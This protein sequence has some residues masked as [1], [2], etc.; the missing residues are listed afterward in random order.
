MIS[1]ETLE[2]SNNRL[3]DLEEVEKLASLPSMV[4]LRMVNN[5]LTK[6]HLY[7]QH[8]L[9][10]LNS[11]K[12][13]DGKDVY[14]DEKERIE[15]LFAAAAAS[16]TASERGME[17]RPVYPTQLVL[18]PSSIP[19]KGSSSVGIP[20]PIEVLTGSHL[21]KTNSPLFSHGQMPVSAPTFPLPE[22]E[23]DLS[24]TVGSSNTTTRSLSLNSYRHNSLGSQSSWQVGAINPASSLPSASTATVASVFG[25]N[26]SKSV[27]GSGNDQLYAGGG[28]RRRITS[29]HYDQQSGEY[30]CF[31]SN[32]SVFFFFY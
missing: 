31:P 23:V 6:K 32:F 21:R 13:L 7:R 28:I 26:L 19:T 8:V 24:I 30:G 12:T 20:Q 17:N 25:A 27:G 29:V 18:T 2:L 4:N 22:H 9:Y 11:L 14:S 1:L 15:M 5:P 10:K 16:A 3:I